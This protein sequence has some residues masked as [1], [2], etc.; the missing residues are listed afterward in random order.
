[1]RA[2]DERD[3]L[4]KLVAQAQRELN[5]AQGEV[6]TAEE[7]DQRAGSALREAKAELEEQRANIQ[8]VAL[9]KPS[10]IA[11]LLARFF[12]QPAVA[13]YEGRMEGVKGKMLCLTR[14]EQ[15]QQGKVPLLYVR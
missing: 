3:E 7:A 4:A 9:S 14:H 1:A 8:S 2:L 6:V 11:F 12:A 5:E 13:S 15:L 10:W